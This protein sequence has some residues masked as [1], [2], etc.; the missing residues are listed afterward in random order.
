LTLQVPSVFFGF[1][2]ICSGLLSLALFAG[3]YLVFSGAQSAIHEQLAVQ[4]AILGALFGLICVVAA[5]AV[6]RDS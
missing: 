2:F 5:I 1:V 4:I 3:C 6:D